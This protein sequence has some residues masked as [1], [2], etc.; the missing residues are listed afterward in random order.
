MFIHTY[1]IIFNT[2]VTVISSDNL[3]SLFRLINQLPR[4]G[5]IT[6]CDR[7]VPAY[8]TGCSFRF[9]FKRL[10]Y[11]FPAL[12]VLIPLR[13]QTVSSGYSF[14]LNVTLVCERLN[15]QQRKRFTKADHT[16]RPSTR[17]STSSSWI[18]FPCHPY[19]FDSYLTDNLGSVRGKLL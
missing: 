15:D 11:R 13:L 19:I 10:S 8:R 4:N 7:Q 14:L 3:L 2:P 9:D 16:N 1:F 5:P 17:G 18:K 6:D 12:H